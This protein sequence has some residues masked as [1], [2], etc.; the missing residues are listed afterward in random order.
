MLDLW[1]RGRYEI[2]AVDSN[3]AEP[4]GFRGVL[5]SLIACEDENDQADG[6]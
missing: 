5:L 4:A 3:D 6:V 1:Q 2:P